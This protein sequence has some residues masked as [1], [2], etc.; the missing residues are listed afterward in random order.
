MKGEAHA[1]SL[2]AFAGYRTLGLVSAEGEYRLCRAVREADDRP[3]LLKAAV[4]GSSRALAALHH[5]FTVASVLDVKDALR[6]LEFVRQRN[7]SAVVFEGFAG[8]SVVDLVEQA[9]LA[10]RV[11]LDLAVKLADALGEIHS[12]RIVHKNLKPSNLL[13]DPRS[14]EVRITGFTIAERMSGFAGAAAPTGPLEGTLAYIPPEQTGRLSR[15]VDCRSDLYSLGIIFYQL[16]TGQLPFVSDDAME[17]VYWHITKP[18]APLTSLNPAVSPAVS[19][20]VLK[21]LAKDPE[22]RYQSAYGLARDLRRCR[23]ELDATGSISDFEPGGED[24]AQELRLPQHLYGRAEERALL[25]ETYDRAAAGERAM[26]LVSGRTGVGK[27]VLAHQLLHPAAERGGHFIAGKFDQFHRDLPYR[28]IIQALQ[29]LTRQLLAHGS[30]RA[31]Y[32]RH[33]LLGALGTNGQVVLRI[34]PELHLIIGPQPEVPELGLTEAT[35]RFNLVMRQFFRALAGADH[36][37]VMFLDDLQWADG[38]SLDLVRL[39]MTDPDISHV[40]L[41]GACREEEPEYLGAV[42]RLLDDLAASGVRTERIPLG[43][44]SPGQVTALLADTLHAASDEL[45]PLAQLVFAKT[46]GNAFFVSEFLKALYVDGALSFDGSSGCWRWNAS[47]VGSASITD[48]VVE[49]VKARMGTLA[50]TTRDV[51]KLGACIGNR[52]GVRQLA[53]VAER[54]VDQ[55]GADLAQAEAE[56]LVTVIQTSP[57][58]AVQRPVSALEAAP[59]TDRAYRFVHDRIQQAAYSMIPPDER[60]AIHARIGRLISAASSP[61]ELEDRL[62][63]VVNQLNAAAEVLRGAEERTELAELNLRAARKAKA[64][65]AYGPAGN[66][67]AAGRRLIGEEGWET[68]Y[69]LAFDLHIE[70][71]EI[72]YLSANYEAMTAFIRIV[73]ERATNE[74]DR[75]RIFELLIQYYNSSM[76]YAQAL[77]T[78]LRAVRMLGEPLPI[79]PHAHDV[80]LG[81]VRTKLALRG[82]SI[83]QLYALPEMSDPYKLA[84]MRIMMLAASAAYF[85]RPNVFPVIV[86]R[87]VRMS[88]RHGSAALSAFAYVCYGLSLCAVLGDMDGGVAFGRLALATVERFGARELNAKVVFLFNVFIHHWK[89]ELS[90]TA[91]GFLDA[92]ASGLES[93]DLEYHSYNLY[94]H[95]AYGFFAGDELEEL[96]HKVRD[97]RVGVAKL[98]QEKVGRLL[99][100]L[101]HVL[102]M[103]RGT[104]AAAAGTGDLLFDEDEQFRLWLERKDYTSLCYGHCFRMLTRYIAGDYQACLASADVIGQ[105]YRSLMGQFFVPFY[106]FYQSLAYAALLPN[107]GAARRLTALRLLRRNRRKLR[108]WASHAPANYRHKLRILDAQYLALRGQHVAALRAFDEAIDLAATA[109]LVQDAALAAELA[110]KCCWELNL[111]TIAQGYLRRAVDNYARWGARGL[112]DRLLAYLASSTG[113]ALPPPADPAIAAS[114]G[115]GRELNLDLGSVMRAAR[116]ISQQV[117]FA[118]LLKSLMAIVLENAGAK[119]GLLVMLRDDKRLIEAEAEDGKPVR[120]LHSAPV[121]GTDKLSEAILDYAIR[122]GEPVVLNDAAGSGPFVADRYVRAARARSVLCAPIVNRGKTIAAVYLENSLVAGAFTPARVE[123]LRLLA[124][125]AAISLRNAELYAG[126]EASLAEQ[127]TLTSAHGRFVPNQFL[128]A[129]GKH[130]IT[131]V[132]VGDYVRKTMTILFADIRAYTALSERMGPRETIQFLNA[133]F[134]EVETAIVSHGG[135]ID[136]YIGDGVMALCE[137]EAD[138]A[139]GAS[140]AIRE[141]LNRFNLQR[142]RDGLPAVDAG[143]GLNTGDVVLGTVGGRNAIRCTVIGDSVNIAARI[144]R[145]TRY[146]GCALLLGDS[147]VRALRNPSAYLIRAI[148]R[149]RVAGR[150]QPITIYESFDADPPEEREAKAATLALFNAALM[151]Y[152]RRDFVDAAVGFAGC[153]ARTPRDRVASLLIERCQR[154][155]RDGVGESWDGVEEVVSK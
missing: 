12:R 9:P 5:E 35:V 113:A 145:L 146:Y 129:L 37:L 121:A 109:G 107:F 74:L 151:A 130:R 14:G 103:L 53:V 46:R 4:D 142:R 122:T 24:I 105:Y 110:G 63:D 134:G 75:A 139:L 71:A 25:L 77:E 111:R 136:S 92:A 67:A 56:E 47:A 131:D 50:A 22:R 100:M 143:I 33:R 55:I 102:V 58:A 26:L 108:R 87:M 125:Q 95:C 18:P 72:A 41:I 119:R 81:L 96:L 127:V 147:T 104:P 106:L 153:I 15:G 85:A 54:S 118:D 34:A 23:D 21:L 116:A 94:M 3:V 82:R 62:F 51:L 49:L 97:F 11:F 27:S 152:Y 36:P 117:V 59:F 135:F 57:E 20:I 89:E 2:P 79:N 91:R 140:I 6:A 132:D 123:L 78:G 70:A 101:E 31:D 65:A 38:A 73:E 120:L 29:E 32:W 137:G 114:G 10:Q 133:Y 90:G 13:L 40:M 138:T 52:F 149:V 66:Y 45:A 8:G 88:I 69:R 7:G 44:L 144:E 124:A 112:A 42:N 83:D 141:A 84:A 99:A 39:L 150:S 43:E 28:A 60:P 80:A 48:N 30:E 64:S 68:H 126:L 148:A 61:Q 16:L 98:K 155:A 93:G 115:A 17:L 128:N 76:Q 86:F 19:R 1:R 154:F